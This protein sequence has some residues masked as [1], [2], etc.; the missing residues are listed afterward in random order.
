M[1]LVNPQGNFNAY[2][3][4]AVG[5]LALT[6]IIA[7]TL[8]PVSKIPNDV[9]NELSIKDI[10]ASMDSSARNAKVQ[11]EVAP[12]NN[13]TPGT[14][15][16]RATVRIADYGNVMRSY[17]APLK[18]KQGQWFRVRYKQG[19]IGPIEVQLSGETAVQDLV[20]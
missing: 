3:E 18:V 1:G 2:G 12:D 13:G 16:I 4:D 9:G 7:Q 19:T 15:A 14:W 6:V 17:T 11:F 10:V 20:V 5:N 8:V